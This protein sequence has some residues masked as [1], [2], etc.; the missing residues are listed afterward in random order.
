VATPVGQT[1]QHDV[2]PAQFYLPIW[3]PTATPHT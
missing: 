3:P 2:R 1:P